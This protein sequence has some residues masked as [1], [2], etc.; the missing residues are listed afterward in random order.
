MTLKDCGAQPLHTATLTESSLPP[1]SPNPQPHAAAG[2]SNQAQQRQD[3]GGRWKL[4]GIFL[5]LSRL[6]LPDLWSGAGILLILVRA[7]RAS[8]GSGW[9]GL[10]GRR[11]RS[12]LRRTGRGTLCRSHHTRRR[13]VGRL[14]DISPSSA[15]EQ[16]LNIGVGIGA[17][18]LSALLGFVLLRHISQA[19]RRI[20]ARRRSGNIVACKH[21]WREI[22]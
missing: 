6:R 13:A 18:L 5:G 14:H 9:R 2:Q 4:L 10:R 12:T 17:G 7:C 20:R 8:H 15:A 22:A 3:R 19:S 21:R 16:V 1:P 11:L